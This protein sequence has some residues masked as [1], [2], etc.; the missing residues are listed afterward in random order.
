M[1]H[2]SCLTTKSD[3]VAV[4]GL[5]L[6]PPDLSLKICLCLSLETRVSQDAEKSNIFS[7]RVSLLHCTLAYCIIIVY[8]GEGSEASMKLPTINKI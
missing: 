6:L 1:V 5:G 8:E 3:G 7:G 2:I 4:D